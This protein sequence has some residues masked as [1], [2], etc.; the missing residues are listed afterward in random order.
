V[1]L[2]ENFVK[3]LNE[4]ENQLEPT[5]GLKHKLRLNKAVKS[6][7]KNYTWIYQAGKESAKTAVEIN[8]KIRELDI[9]SFISKTT[10]DTIA[11]PTKDLKTAFDKV[12]S[13]YSDMKQFDYG[14]DTKLI[15]SII[16]D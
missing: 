13:N 7:D 8:N 9:K 4:K 5:G 12:V 3:R 10:G 14:D 6:S 16:E 11:I 1:K 2:F 15:D